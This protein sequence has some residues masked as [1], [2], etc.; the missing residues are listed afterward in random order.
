[1]SRHRGRGFVRGSR[2]ATDWSASA[3]Q[4]GSVAIAA[5][6]K[7]LLQTFVPIAGGETVIRTRGTFS[8]ASDQFAASELQIGA[9]GICIVSDIAAAAGAA[10]I[11][12]PAT[13][14][15][16]GGW[17]VHQYFSRWLEF[18]SAVGIEPNFGM[19]FE[20]DSKA[21]RKIDENDRLVVMVENST[22]GHGIEV[23][24]SFRFLTKVH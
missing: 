24:E 15:D 18:A 10:S 16:W 1:M 4:V 20:I 22:A 23:M 14:A 17:F 21:M 5:A 6:T 11:P 9:L 13:N 8:V 19:S 12:G 7:A 3:A 2:K